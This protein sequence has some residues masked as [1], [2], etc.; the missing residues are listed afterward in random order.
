MGSVLRYYL[1]FLPEETIDIVLRQFS[2][3]YKTSLTLWDQLA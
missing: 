3:K 2:S 1:F